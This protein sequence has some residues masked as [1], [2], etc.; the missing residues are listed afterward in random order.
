MINAYP[1]DINIKKLDGWT[2]LHSSAYRGSLECMMIL[3][4]NNG[5]ATIESVSGN[6]ALHIASKRGNF[7]CVE[8]LVQRSLFNFDYINHKNH[9]EET[10][11]D[12]AITNKQKRTIE[13]LLDAGAVSFKSDDIESSIDDCVLE[14]KKCFDNFV[15]DY[16]EYPL[17]KEKL[18]A[19]ID[20]LP[21]MMPAAGYL[22]ARFEVNK[23]Y[24]NEVLFLVHLNIAQ[25]YTNC[26]P[27]K[28][29]GVLAYHSNN[30]NN[31]NKTYLLMSL[32]KSFLR[33]LLFR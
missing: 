7:R 32:L 22:S 25:V 28:N 20:I 11:L 8:L 13:I 24:F 16:I 4:D 17:W 19:K 14:K 23:I 31:S 29:S 9:Y 1:S 33:Q 21:M 30:S 10:A 18:I 27:F 5:D 3:L 26:D 6:L 15:D 12:G 2:C